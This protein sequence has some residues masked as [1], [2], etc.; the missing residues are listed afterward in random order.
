MERVNGVV[1]S[2]PPSKGAAR[3]GE[4]LEKLCKDQAKG[5]GCGFAGARA[6]R[7]VLPSAAMGG[8]GLSCKEAEGT[9]KISL[10]LGA[11]GLSLVL[12][13]DLIS[14][15]SLLGAGVISAPL[16]AGRG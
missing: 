14:P 8:S 4:T 2:S 11:E 5:N 15:G 16:A 13:L 10:V 6:L 7:A 1:I 9:R 3:L 12:S